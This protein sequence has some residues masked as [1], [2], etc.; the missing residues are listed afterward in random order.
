MWR[1]FPRSRSVQL[2]LCKFNRN[3]RRAIQYHF[4]K[5]KY[6]D[7]ILCFYGRRR[8]KLQAKRQ[9]KLC[10]INDTSASGYLHVNHTQPV[11]QNN[12][13]T[14]SISV[15][16]VGSET[17]SASWSGSKTNSEIAMI[18][19][20]AFS[21]GS[22]FFTSNIVLASGVVGGTY[23]YFGPDQFCTE[24]ASPVTIRR[25]Q[26]VEIDHKDKSRSNMIILRNSCKVWYI[27]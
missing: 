20:D 4:W 5:S 15:A 22:T 25:P 17:I 18:I 14:F 1:N 7:G 3:Y 19:R 9:G 16:N 11:S 21:K 2:S 13:I 10:V 6:N 26:I 27:H 12:Y 8:N 23:P 24:D